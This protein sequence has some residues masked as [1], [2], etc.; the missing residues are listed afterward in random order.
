MI[1]LHF[2][3]GN[4]VIW[5]ISYFYDIRELFHLRRKDENFVTVKSSNA[6]FLK[7]KIVIKM[8]ILSKDNVIDHETFLPEIF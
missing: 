3:R 6:T 2:F 1:L 4:K 7:I 8:S 5:E